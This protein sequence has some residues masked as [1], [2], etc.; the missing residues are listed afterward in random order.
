M[1]PK[2]RT[3]LEKVNCNRNSSVANWQEFG[4]PWSD[5]LAYEKQHPLDE[6]WGDPWSHSN[7]LDLD[8]LAS[9]TTEAWSTFLDESDS[10]LDTSWGD[11]WETTSDAGVLSGDPWSASGV[12][13][14]SGTQPHD[15]ASAPS[16]DSASATAPEAAPTCR[17]SYHLEV[18]AKLLSTSSV[19]G[20]LRTHYEVNG[21]SK[22][23]IRRRLQAGCRRPGCCK[24]GC[25]AGAFELEPM[26]DFLFS[27]WSLTD[28][29]RG[30][31]LRVVA[32]PTSGPAEKSIPCYHLLGKPVCFPGMCRLMGTSEPTVRRLLNG[33]PDL[34]KRQ[35]S[36]SGQSSG[37]ALPS[38]AMQAA[39][40]HTFFQQLHQSAAAPDP[41]Q[42][43]DKAGVSGGS[44]DQLGH[45][46]WAYNWGDA[47][48]L[49]YACSARVIGLPVRHS[50][51]TAML[52]T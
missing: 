42:D 34:R 2:K 46:D 10:D 23:Q 45:A 12:S 26:A 40:C 19:K 36:N 3:K 7:D 48:P 13:G 51:G 25:K 5:V 21:G 30:H 27:Y 11:P 37:G 8:D 35:W 24:A 33:I 15:S 17:C 4:D 18:G 31:L 14:V 38:K 29:E 6:S 44:G 47:D 16:G 52:L 49:S 39:K 20:E 9:C 50:P 1:P 32:A 28:E 22:E 41:G 43:P